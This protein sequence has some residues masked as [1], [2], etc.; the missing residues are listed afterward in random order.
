M[1]VEKHDY[2]LNFDTLLYHNF[3]PFSTV[4]YEHGDGFLRRLIL[5]L[6]LPISLGAERLFIHR[7]IHLH[8]SSQD[9]PRRYG[10]L[11]TPL[12]S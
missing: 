1:R 3:R 12:L 2:F 10:I 7:Q 8:I 9:T 5:C 6:L 4:L 11:L